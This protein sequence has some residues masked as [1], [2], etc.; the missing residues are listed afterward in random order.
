MLGRPS[1]EEIIYN[2][3]APDSP[4]KVRSSEA[5]PKRARN[6]KRRKLSAALSL[7]LSVGAEGQPWAGPL[8]W[9]L[10]ML[11]TRCSLLCFLM[12]SN[13]QDGEE[14]PAVHTQDDQEWPSQQRMP[15]TFLML[16]SHL[17]SG[18]NAEMPQEGR[19][20]L[21]IWALTWSGGPEVRSTARELGGTPHVFLLC[22]WAM[23]G[24][25]CSVL[26]WQHLGS[27]EKLV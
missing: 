3:P 14:G 26:G 17:E 21:T 2:V 24:S 6:V 27:D 18:D 16:T 10:L 7:T 15:G 1:F 8:R 19:P 13:T 12:I 25:S 23:P 22:L 20:G 4:K 11:R 5:K 9:G